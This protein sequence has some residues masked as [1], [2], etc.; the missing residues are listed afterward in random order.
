MYT[1]VSGQHVCPIFRGP[2]SKIKFD[3]LTLDPKWQR[4]INYIL[5]SLFHLHL[6]LLSI[7][8][9]PPPGFQIN[10][11]CCISPM[12]YTPHLPLSVEYNHPKNNIFFWRVQVM[13]L[14]KI[15]SNLVLSQNIIASTFGVI[16]RPVVFIGR[17][18][19]TR[20]L[21]HLSGSRRP[22]RW[23]QQS[24]PKRRPINTTGRVITPKLEL[25]I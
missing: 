8:N 24:V 7:S 9:P 17:R 5:L 23:N 4:L 6:G 1:D 14:D 2:S 10:V 13:K 25:I 11:I 16:T 21:S 22:R 18:F 12:C 20:C 15:F 3:C 19:G